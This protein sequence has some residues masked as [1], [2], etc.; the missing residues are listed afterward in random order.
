M[1]DDPWSPD[2]FEGR[3]RALESRYHSHHP[4]NVR[5]NA[6]QLQP[7]QVR[8]WV[9]NRYY[10]QCRIPMKDAAILANCEDR[11]TRRRWVE[12]IVDHD[13]R[14]GDAAQVG[15]I[16]IWARLGEAT[17]LD[18]AALDAFTHVVPGVCFA[19]DAYVNFA[20][21]APWQEAV[22]SS[23]TEMFAPKIHRDRLAG[24]PHHYPWI[25]DDGLAYFRTRIPLA[26]RDVEHGLEVA[27]TWC[28]TRARQQRAIDI[29][30]FKLDVLWSMLDAI[31][32]AYPDDLEGAARP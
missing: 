21:Q 26:S 31:E 29:L 25:R 19:V 32:R 9:A 27:R 1:T 2:A 6:G 3:L 11:A 24:W 10:Y 13:G 4:F 16:E 28:T 15:G 22:I 7:F 18:R 14:D 17:G 12:R 5:L 30:A 8:G 23:L 20:R